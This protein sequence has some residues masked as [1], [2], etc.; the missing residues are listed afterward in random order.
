[1]AREA[2]DPRIRAK[3]SAFARPGKA[4]F[5]AVDD[6]SAAALEALLDPVDE[7]LDPSEA[8]VNAL[9]TRGDQ[10]DEQRQVVDAR[11][12]LRLRV[13]LEC[14][15]TPNHLVRQASDLR[16]VAPD[17][18]D[19]FAQAVLNGVFD[20]RG[21]R[22]RSLGSGLREELEVPPRPLEHC[23][24]RHSIYTLLDPLLCALDRAL[25]HARQL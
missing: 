12:T 21:Q 15:E 4:V 8:R 22:L 7:R 14:L 24:E 5:D 19:L 11:V 10:V 13:A 1:L 3:A 20:A 23:I 17:G 9:P 25:I 16:E 6:R 18:Q 2:G